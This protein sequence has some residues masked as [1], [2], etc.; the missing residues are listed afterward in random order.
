MTAR[1]PLSL[2]KSPQIDGAAPDALDQLRQW[3]AENGVEEIECVI[4]DLAGIAR[5]KVMPA[6]KFL[7]EPGLRL[8]MSTFFATINGDYTEEVGPQLYTD[9]D[10]VLTPDYGAIRAVPWAN[11]R[12]L[13]VMHDAQTEDGS[14]F[15][16]AP[17]QVLKRVVDLYAERGWFPIVAP[18]L[19]FYLV[20]P[21]TDPDYPLEPPVGRSGRQSVGNQAFSLSAVDEYDEVIELI[22]DYAD[23]QNLAIDT[24]IQES[25]PAQLEI[26]LLHGDPVKLAD[27]VFLFKRMIREAALRCGTYATFMA[28]PYG[29][30][31]G[32]AMHI[33]MSVTDAQG[34][35]IFSDAEGRATEAHD[36]FVG[37]QQEYFGAATA[38][39]APY[40]NSYRRLIP[41]WSAP[42]NLDWGEDNR[43]TGLRSPRATPAARRVENRVAGADANPYLALAATLA[44]GYLGLTEGL[45]PRVL[46]KGNSYSRDRDLPFSLLDAATALGESEPLRSVLGDGFVD[47]FTAVKRSEYEQFM[48]VISPWE[49]QHLLLNV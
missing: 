48:Q 5:G 35:N 36:A 14:A 22:Y 38:L 33:H 26:N 9:P 47:T 16:I 40:V 27:E 30:Q 24:I 45:K 29:Q 46:V 12:S 20:K 19:E 13:Q 39:V 10:L 4:P 42:I 3:V 34:G 43:T 44:C 25:G 23:A 8:P 37:G 2:T 17:R 7:R 1:N 21:N 31:V 32:S 41:G 28:K 11:D 18:E 6:A 15:G 49:R